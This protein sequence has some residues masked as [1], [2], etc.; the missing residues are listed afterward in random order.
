MYVALSMPREKAR[1]GLT[2]LSAGMNCEKNRVVC[3]GYYEKQIW[4][5]GREIAEEGA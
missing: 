1:H 3:E 2:R 5:S 4:K